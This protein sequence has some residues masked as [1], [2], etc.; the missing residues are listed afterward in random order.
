MSSSRDPRDLSHPPFP[1]VQVIM[2]ESERDELR[3][4]QRD[5]IPFSFKHD[6]HWN[7]YAHRIVGGELTRVVNSL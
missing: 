3:N 5:A 1:R 7:A 2:R 6:G 4:F